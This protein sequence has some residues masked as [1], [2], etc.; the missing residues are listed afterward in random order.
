MLIKCMTKEEYS[1]YRHNA[2]MRRREK[3]KAESREYYKKHREEILARAK[4][5]Y[6]RKCGL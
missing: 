4:L 1:V 5:R 6:R 3:Q 2:Y